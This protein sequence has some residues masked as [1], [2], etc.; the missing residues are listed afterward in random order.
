MNLT[1][2]WTGNWNNAI[3]GMRNPWESWD[4][5]D[6]IQEHLGPNDTKLACSLIKRGS[7][8][9]KFLRQ[10]FVSFEFTASKDFWSEFDTY[11]YTVRNSTSMTHK[12]GHKLLSAEDFE[13]VTE[14]YLELMNVYVKAW[15]ENKTPENKRKM[16]ASITNDFLYTSMIAT[17]YEVILGAIYFA[18]YMHEKLEWRYLASELRKLPN[19]DMFLKV[20]EEK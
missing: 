17:N 19:M 20:L 10:I 11:E 5:N 18:R 2:I 3:Y 1:K 7:S 9:R 16:R 15:Q 6:S 8:D 14:A 4:K 13:W 12:L